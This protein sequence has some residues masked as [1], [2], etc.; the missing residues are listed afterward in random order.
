MSMVL[1]EAMASCRSSLFFPSTLN[2][3]PWILTWTLS[4]SFLISAITFLA[5][6]W[7][8]PSLSS[9]T[10]LIDPPDAPSR[11]EERRVGKDIYLSN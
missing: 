5:F 8:M 11:S 2:S 7:L 1:I 6:S 10:C 4:F 9:L 3:S